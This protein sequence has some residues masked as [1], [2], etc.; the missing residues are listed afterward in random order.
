MKKNNKKRLL[1]LLLTAIMIMITITQSEIISYSIVNTAEND[2]AIISKELD[3]LFDESQ[4]TQEE[5][6]ALEEP[7]KEDGTIDIMNMNEFVMPRNASIL[8]MSTGVPIDGYLI[9]SEIG[10]NENKTIGTSDNNKIFELLPG[11]GKGIVKVAAGVTTTL[12]LNGATRISEDGTNDASKSPIQIAA[13][14]N[15][16]IVLADGTTNVMTCNGTDSASNAFQAGIYVSPEATLKITGTGELTANSGHYSAGIGGVANRGC[17]DI[18]IESGTVTSTARFSSG[19]SNAAGIGGGGSNSYINF[20]K[21]GT[22]KICGTAHV[23]ATS[24]GSGA[25]IGSGG[26]SYGSNSPNG[27]VIISDNATVI[28]TSMGHGAG[29]GGGGFNSV[30]SVGGTGA[31]E[32]VT[33]EAGDGGTI[34]ISG[35]ANVTATGKKNGAGIGGGGVEKFNT[36]KP[37]RAGNGGNI[38]ISDNAVVTAKSEMLG[39]GIGGGSTGVTGGLGLTPG[40]GG[41]IHISGNTI[42]EASGK[43]DMGAGL[44]DPAVSTDTPVLGNPGTITITSGNVYADDTKSDVVTNGNK[45]APDI[46]GRADIKGAPIGTKIY[47]AISPVKGEYDYTAT[48]N[49]SGNAYLWLP[50]GN[51]LVIY[52]NTYEPSPDDII[53]IKI[54]TL[55]Q[56]VPKSIEFPE[57]TGLLRMKDI[58]TVTWD[59]INPLRTI[60]YEY[61]KIIK[62]K[63]LEEDRTATEY[64][65]DAKIINSNTSK[66]ITI[67]DNRVYEVL[68]T[69]NDIIKVINNAKP[70][71]VFNNAEFI[72]PV[73]SSIAKPQTPLQLEPGTEAVV[74]LLEGTVN[75]FTCQGNTANTLAPQA[76]IDV[77]KGAVLTIKREI[78]DLNEIE[79]LSSVGVLY[80]NGGSYGAGI[81]AGPNQANGKITIIGGNITATAAGTV[82]PGANNGAGIGGGGGNSYANKP[83]NEEIIICGDAIVKAESLGHGAGIGS[84]ASNINKS[85]NAG[86]IIIRGNVKVTAISRG[87]GAGIGGGGS[88]TSVAGANTSIEIYGSAEVTASSNG[89]GAGIGGGGVDSTGAGVSGAGGTIAIYG[90]DTDEAPIIVASSA[91]GLDMGSGSKN[92]VP[93]TMGSI[94]IIDGNVW[95]VHNKTTKVTNGA[96]NHE[97]V[98][99]RR[100]DD[101]DNENSIDNLLHYIATG[102]TAQYDYIAWT[103]SNTNGDA[104][105]WRPNDFVE[106]TVEEYPIAGKIY[107]ETDNSHEKV[108]F[109]ISAKYTDTF[110]DED[111]FPLIDNPLGKFEW[112]R[113]PIA[114]KTKYGDNDIENTVA[115]F[116]DKYEEISNNKPSNCGYDNNPIF[117]NGRYELDFTADKNASYWFKITYVDT[118]GEPCGEMYFKYIVDNFYTP[119]EVFVRD[120]KVESGP[121]L[122]GLSDYVKLEKD[123]NLQTDPDTYGIPFDL[124]GEATGTIVVGAEDGTKP[125]RFGYD[126][127]KYK[128]YNLAEELGCKLDVPEPPFDIN[129]YD[130]DSYEI[131][132]VLDGDVAKNKNTDKSTDEPQT[133]WAPLD[134]TLT[135]K[136]YTANYIKNFVLTIKNTLEGEYSN[137]TLPFDFTITFKGKNNS[138]Y[139]KEIGYRITGASGALIKT[140]IFTLEDGQGEFQL[141]HG[142]KIDFYSFE[143]D[144]EVEIEV[145]QASA[146]GYTTTNKKVIK[147]PGNE[148]IIN[149]S[150]MAQGV[151]EAN[152]EIR[153]VNVKSPIVASG[154][155][156][157][158]GTGIIIAA[159]NIMVLLMLYLIFDRRKIKQ[160]R[161]L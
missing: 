44:V 90:N 159:I 102:K 82:G 54:E 3:A 32:L 88:V 114:D 36:D 46:V 152:I 133:P 12:V 4:T 123:K 160:L 27:T 34:I 150:T 56:N 118:E 58:Q 29:I 66:V 104:Y 41:N 71:F 128:A 7:L 83:N 136:Y 20:P 26:T 143:E 141:K 53:R 22:I 74:V 124:D 126:T 97:I 87:N 131:K 35:N 122:V 161:I 47:E 140:G 1:T 10:V 55:E 19:P 70:V 145:T 17:G 52:R 130:P 111:G 135:E 73:N 121:I 67:S 78:I 113:V 75:T 120:A 125:L 91:S 93:G 144:D 127:V 89:S 117:N 2:S 48:R 5:T 42:V 137:N 51:Q 40:N 16:T 81:G 112:F 39:T 116:D 63:A 92:G 28:A 11:S 149:G 115:A 9:D 142:E 79:D 15:V 156:L 45:G 30:G 23:T 38:T 157:S 6:P 31:A 139:I 103:H 107:I 147:I 49:S 105:V 154:V 69:G 57:E 43:R 132:I 153:Y 94:T 119:I 65:I 129:T 25:G 8:P 18:T 21:V 99:M 84:G 64:A 151:I 85:S 59:G 50:L 95:A 33:K 155:N 76:G 72:S 101:P 109:K 146:N 106:G 13:N 37:V 68:G 96:P 61:E 100:I 148:Q 77:P 60:E 158:N 110:V 98:K 80:A 138:D 62:I 14:A 86:S 108:H 134:S 24:N